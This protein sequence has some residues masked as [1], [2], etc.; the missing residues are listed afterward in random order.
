MVLRPFSY[1][2]Q[3]VTETVASHVPVVARSF[4]MWVSYIAICLRH[5]TK[6]TS[7]LTITS[8]GARAIV[9]DEPTCVCCRIVSYIRLSHWSIDPAHYC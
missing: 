6:P 7:V 4:L 9:L 1:V 3:S 5:V 2:T 8:T